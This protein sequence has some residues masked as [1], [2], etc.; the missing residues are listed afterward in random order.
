MKNKTRVD[1]SETIGKTVNGDSIPKYVVIEMMNQGSVV[2]K[3]IKIGDKTLM[4]N[5]KKVYNKKYRGKK[6]WVGYIRTDEVIHGFGLN[7]KLKSTIHIEVTLAVNEDALEFYKHALIWDNS[8]VNKEREVKLE[9]NLLL[10]ETNTSS[11][12]IIVNSEEFYCKIR[13]VYIENKISGIQ[14]DLDIPKI[15]FLEG[16]RPKY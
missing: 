15:N 12:E 4:E 2:P 6:D 16:I 7:D 11:I 1:F 13:E 14:I 3:Y 9:T 10:I 5:G 8:E